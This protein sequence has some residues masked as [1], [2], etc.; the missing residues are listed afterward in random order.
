M[1]IFF[2]DEDPLLAARAHF[3]KH[4][5][6]MCSEYAQLLSSAKRLLDGEERA[7][8]INGRKRKRWFMERD[9]E[10]RLYRVFNPAHPS[11][12]WAREKEANY[13]FLYRLYT[14][15]LE[16][17]TFRYGK[18]HKAGEI[19]PLLAEPPRNIP[20]KGNPEMSPPPQ[21][22]EEEYRRKTAQ[23]GYRNLYR[24]GKAHL[25]GYTGREPPGWL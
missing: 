8:E 4:V 23:E 16:E 17:Y 25:F 9:G 6:K 5:V 14:A 11:N 13:N 2:L 3:D 22:M 18:S 20:E 15:L 7:L 21:V 19:A 12:L 10:T 24:T 1:N